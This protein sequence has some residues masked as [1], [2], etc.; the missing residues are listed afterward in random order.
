CIRRAHGMTLAKARK[1]A[2]KIAD[3]LAAEFEMRHAWEGSTLTFSRSGVHGSIVV[4]V[5]DVEVRAKLGFLLAFL[6]PK[7]EQEIHRF[8]DQNFP[9]KKSSGA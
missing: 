5:K 1:A 7:I 9:S 6:R 4:G 8:C 3:E 2:E